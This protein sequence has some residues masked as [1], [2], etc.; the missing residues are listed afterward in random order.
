M[1]PSSLVIR[2]H[3]RERVLSP[4]WRA[5]CQLLGG[6]TLC[7]IHYLGAL[8][9]GTHYLTVEKQSEL[10]H[11]WCWWMPGLRAGHPSPQAPPSMLGHS[12]LQGL[13]IHRTSHFVGIQFSKGPCN[14]WR[15]ECAGVRW[16][17]LRLQNLEEVFP[18]QVNNISLVEKL[19]FAICL[20]QLYM[21][22]AI[23]K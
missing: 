12:A 8:K 2:P 15:K 6:R 20:I 7:T 10:S 3:P 21:A 17:P 5:L 9:T 4:I 18:Y 16:P 11:C 22:Y 13:L 1:E 19:S 14:Q 23:K